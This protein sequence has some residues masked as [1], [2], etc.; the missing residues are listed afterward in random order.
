MAAKK[1]LILI[2]PSTSHPVIRFTLSLFYN[3]PATFSLFILPA[4]TPEDYTIKIYNQKLF[5]SNK[6]FIGGSLVGISCATSNSYEAYKIADRFRKAGSTVIMGGLHPSYFPQEALQHCNSVV[7]GEAESVWPDLV[8][9]Y[10]NKTLRQAYKGE[11]LADYFSP[12]YN[13]FLKINPRILYK[14]GILL[15]R[16]C[17]YHCDFCVPH[18]GGLRLIKL[19]QALS[20]VK[21]VRDGVQLPFGLKPT[22]MFRDDNIFSSPE[23]A[24]RLFAGLSPL[25]LNW[26]GNSSIDIAFDDEALKAAKASGCKSLF[27][28]FE[29]IY[30][31]KLQ[32]TST[33]HMRSTDDYIKAIKKIRSYHIK[34]T[35]AFILG[36]DYYTHKDYLRL[37][38]FLI[39]SGLYS[40]SLTIL[41]PFPASQLYERLKHENRITTF[42]W[43]KYDSLH[44][45]VFRPKHMC[46]LSLSLWFIAL[47]VVGLLA[48]PYFIIMELQV[49]A[50]FYLAFYF[51]SFLKSRLF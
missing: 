23:Y 30:P 45:V 20:L 16:G 51:T 11:P 15:S 8:R 7:I 14:T 26:T 43:R 2:L 5:W 31:Q 41:T 25:R 24:K 44:H 1:K 13:Y 22:I 12:S 6:D 33:G 9:D 34:V 36:F 3:A 35:G 21:K 40:I 48:S 46:A 17:K 29:T 32:K 38:W 47:R 28:G 10:E 4:L 19:D 50:E 18:S 27:I 37:M 49:L 42:D 39:R